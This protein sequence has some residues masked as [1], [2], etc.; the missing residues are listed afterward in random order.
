MALSVT[1]NGSLRG[2]IHF[3][4]LRND[5][6]LRYPFLSAREASKRTLELAEEMRPAL[7]RL[8]DRPRKMEDEQ[9]QKS[10][11]SSLRKNCGTG[12]TL[13]SELRTRRHGAALRPRVA[14]RL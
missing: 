13:N 12:W 14:G 6:E 1:T 2:G 11:S 10:L 8:P 5:A 7:Q 3:V 9:T 4:I